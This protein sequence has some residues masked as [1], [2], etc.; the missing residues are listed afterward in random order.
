ML[1]ALYTESDGV[2]RCTLM[3]D[4]VINRYSIVCVDEFDGFGRTKSVTPGE[5]LDFLIEKAGMSI[6]NS[7]LLLLFGEVAGGC[8]EGVVDE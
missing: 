2:E 5:A 8:F 4:N 1:E 3:L 7:M 6:Q